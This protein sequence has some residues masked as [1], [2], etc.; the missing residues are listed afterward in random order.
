M[1]VVLPRHQGMGMELC[2]V[3]Q[4]SPAWHSPGQLCWN[5]LAALMEGLEEVEALLELLLAFRRQL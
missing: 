4:S 1:Q 2:I 3:V 5:A